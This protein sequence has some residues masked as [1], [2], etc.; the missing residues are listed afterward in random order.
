VDGPPARD[1]AAPDL[2]VAA[3]LG[4]VLEGLLA[5][6]PWR[7]GIALGD[8]ARRWAEVVGERLAA[9]SQ[10]ARLD[11]GGVLVV[12]VSTAPW[13]AQLRFLADEVRSLA[14]E[15]LGSPLIREVRIVL[16]GPG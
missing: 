4:G 15:S 5:G 14:N 9:E 3:G 7:S 11:D 13:A 12:R 6:T 16:Q 8:L 10:P 1:P 2:E